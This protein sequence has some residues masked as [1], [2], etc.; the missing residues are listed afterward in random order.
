MRQVDGA[1]EAFQPVKKLHLIAFKNQKEMALE[2][3]IFS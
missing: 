2:I 3:V 1:F